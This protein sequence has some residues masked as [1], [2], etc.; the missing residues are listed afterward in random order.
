[1]IQIHGYVPDDFAGSGF[2]VDAYNRL[3]RTE[4]IHP[5]TEPGIAFQ[6]KP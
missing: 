3:V 1:M 4:A 6:Q 2:R 5:D